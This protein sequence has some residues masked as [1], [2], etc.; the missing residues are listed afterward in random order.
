[1][2]VCECKCICQRE[3]ESVRVCVCVCVCERGRVFDSHHCLKQ[4]TCCVPDMV[5]VLSN[6][7]V[8]ASALGVQRQVS[9]VL[10]L[11]FLWMRAVLY[12]YTNLDRA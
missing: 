9:L 12:R 1:M 8:S 10:L 3:R 6:G 2:C 5:C 7:I 11:S 4:M